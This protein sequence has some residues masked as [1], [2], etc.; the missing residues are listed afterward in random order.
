MSV[1]SATSTSNSF[2]PFVMRRSSAQCQIDA[3]R[4]TGGPRKHIEW[5]RRCSAGRASRS[6]LADRTT[7]IPIASAA[8][9]AATMKTGLLLAPLSERSVSC[10]CLVRCAAVSTAES[11]PASIDT[12][13]GLPF[14][15]LIQPRSPAPATTAAATSVNTTTAASAWRQVVRSTKRGYFVVR[16]GG[17]VRRGAW[18]PQLEH[19]GTV[20]R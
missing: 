18:L 7:V 5:R 12:T 3:T 15:V 11:E 20:R 8:A 17:G 2:A 9:R 19:R 13:P 4:V 1:C 14:G 16:L 6:R 10:A